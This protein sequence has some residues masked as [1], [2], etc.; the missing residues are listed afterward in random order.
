MTRTGQA[1]ALIA[2]TPEPL[3][4]IN[5]AD[6]AR[7]GLAEGGLA[8]VE[9]T[10]GAIVLRAEPTHAQRRGKVFVPMHWTGQFAQ[11]GP[12]ARA[13]GARLDPHSGQPEL[14]ATPARV[15]AVEAAWH[16]LLLRRAG[17]RLP[18]LCHWMRVPVEAGQVYRLAG[19]RSMP[20]GADLAHLA[21]ALLAAPGADLLE[22]SDPARGVLRVA[23]LVE[24]R[25]EAGLLT[26]RDPAAL[27]QAEILLPLLGEIVPDAARPALLAGRAHTDIPDDG[28]RVCA[29]FG[30]RLNAIRHAAITHRLR[31]IAELGDAVR[32]GTGCGS[33]VPE[34]ERILRDVRAPA[35]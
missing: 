25:L 13:V 12:V 28:P 34:L 18:H 33:C 30:V 2:H 1:T 22:A 26:A 35:G 5:P 24:G 3:L 27:P 23:A 9:T 21:E 7:L 4:A 10:E 31:T 14:K 20:H 8:R 17:E 16:G 11:S 19:L 15:S 32:A 6:A 29:C